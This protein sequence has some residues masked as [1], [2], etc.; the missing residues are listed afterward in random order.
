MA[1]RYFLKDVLYT[2]NFKNRFGNEYSLNSAD[3]KNHEEFSL[4]TKKKRIIS[5][6]YSEMTQL[7]GLIENA[8]D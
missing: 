5:L 4:K 1:K 2:A 6:V 8:A 3:S 7:T